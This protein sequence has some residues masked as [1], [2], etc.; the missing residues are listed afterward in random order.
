MALCRRPSDIDVTE[1]D[2]EDSLD[3][4]AEAEGSVMQAFLK[5]IRT[6]LQHELSPKFPAL[7]AKWLL[8]QLKESS[9]WLRAERAAWA[10][11]KLSAAEQQ[12]AGLPVEV[13]LAYIRDVYVWLPDVRWPGA[14]PCCPGCFEDDQVGNNG[15][16]SKH[17]ARRCVCDPDL[18][19]LTRPQ[20]HS[21]F[22]AGWLH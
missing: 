17:Y 18:S 13:E 3:S 10:L 14:M 16:L 4:A 8:T 21:P 6:R 20:V 1:L 7:H 19:Y 22:H 9:W 15:F 11:G 2:E 12:E 5:A